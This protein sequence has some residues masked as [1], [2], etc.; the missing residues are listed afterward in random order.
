VTFNLRWGGLT[1]VLLAT[2]TITFGSAAAR[3]RNWVTDHRLVGVT[4]GASGTVEVDGWFFLGAGWSSNN[5]SSQPTID[6]TTAKGLVLT[7]QMSNAN[8][9]TAQYQMDTNLG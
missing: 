4:T 6:T 7:V 1:G 9:S 5:P 8:Y 3:Q 2:Y